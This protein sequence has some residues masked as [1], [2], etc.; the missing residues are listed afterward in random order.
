MNHGVA[1]ANIYI[2]KLKYQIFPIRQILGWSTG[3]L[4]CDCSDETCPNLGKHPRI[5]WSK[6][7]GTAAMWEKWPYDGFGIATGKRSGIWVL[8]VDPRSGGVETLSALEQKHAPLP[9]TITVLTGSQ[10]L[11]FYFKYPGPDYRNTAGA[12]GHGL[13]TR[14]DGGYVVGAGSLH[15][16]G[17][18][19]T[20]QKG[21]AD[22]ELAEAPEW[23]LKMVRQQ[24]K[25]LG[26]NTNIAEGKQGIH[27]SGT[28][29]LESKLLL[30]YMTDDHSPLINWMRDWP[31]E[32]NR[33]TWRGVA[34]NL[35]AAALGHPD[36]LEIAREKFHEISCKYSKYR[37]S[38]TDNVFRDSVEVAATYGPM[39]YE[40]MVKSGMPADYV[41]PSDARNLV[42]YA[43]LR[44]HEERAR[45]GAQVVLDTT[46][47]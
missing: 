10:G 37:P 16:S 35:A 31:E 44:M 3:E 47:H 28:S 15:K 22:T 43:R 24:P 23:L 2:E 34:T 20:W 12:L 13:D 7:V 1:I 41:L 8:D 4:R 38:E 42:H 39:T 19:Y 36:L 9:K 46:P 14:G 40:H 21:P 32:V 25:K 5:P 29:W 17:R 33:E 45:V 18:R 27:S 6:E 11:H 26:L 30:Q